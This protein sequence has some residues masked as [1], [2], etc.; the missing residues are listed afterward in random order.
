MELARKHSDRLPQLKEM[1]EAS[2]LYFRKNAERYN[3][4]MRFVFDTSLTN[5]DLTKLASLG[6][7]TLEFNVLEA[8]VSRLRGEFAKQEPGIMVR[9][10]DGVP[11]EKLTPDFIK[12][13]EVIEAYLREIITDSSND[14]LQYNVY[15][16]LLGGGYSVVEMFTDYIN[17]LSFDQQIIARRVFDPTLTGFDP[18]AR[19]SHKGDGNYCFQLY[20]KSKEEFQEEFG[21]E[22]TEDMKFSRGIGDFS[23]SYNTQKKDIIL[24]CDFYEKKRK[25]I[26]IVKLS[27][28][29]I[30]NKKHYEELLEEWN[31]REFI[32]VP[33]IPIEERDSEM[34]HIVRYRFCETKVLSYDET[35]YKF[36][37]LVFIDGN[38]IEIKDYDNNAAC[39]MTR[40]YAYHAK[41]IQ[42]LK[43][44]SGQ[45]VGAEIENMVQHKFKVCIEAIP[46]DFQEAYRNVQQADVLMYNAFYKDN[47]EVQLPPPMEIQRTPTPPIVESTFLGSDR[48]TQAILGNYDSVLGTND[49]DISGIG[50]AN[51]AIQSSAASTPYLMGYIKGLNRICQIAVDLIPK[52]YVTPRSLPI[53]TPDGKR[54]YQLINKKSQ[55]GQPT[56]QSVEINYKPHELQV[57]VEAGVNTAIQKQVALEQIIRMMQASPLFAQFINTSGLETIL[58][59]MDIRGIEGLK[60]KALEFQEML[61][62]QQEEQAQQPDPMQE[63]TKAAM[64]V[65]MAKIEQKSEEAEANLA[66]QSAK[67]ALEKE[68]INAQVA[69]IMND[70]E[71]KNA[72]ILLDQDKVDSENART[73]IESA[74]D[75]SER[76]H[77]RNEAKQEEPSE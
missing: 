9:A 63:M 46:E 7:P 47:P 77:Q 38:S 73:A 39:Q 45:T 50:I 65:E 19:E 53:R 33:P 25:K 3:E 49:K 67:V 4:F 35:D 68:K 58:D 20:P 59:N 36:L 22:A 40:P 6:K 21:E 1:V 41:G 16:D 30:I 42:R 12:M 24:V 2:Y 62:K 61:K 66:V 10:S 54:S 28:G 48:V 76:I 26:K 11:I 70:I 52:Y 27:N 43:N 74:M 37:P 75:I 56:Q 57:K 44:F 51:G 72:K 8:M 32:E 14:G 60:V 71:V 64:D 18:L 31:K 23:W 15:T 29:H 13:L 55:N 17:E 34:E 69:A 5:D